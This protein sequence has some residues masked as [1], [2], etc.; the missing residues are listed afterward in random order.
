MNNNLYKILQTTF[1]FLHFA[2]EWLGGFVKWAT[3]YFGTTTQ[4]WYFLSHLLL[5]P[6]LAMPYFIKKQSAYIMLSIQMAIFVNVL[7]HLIATMLFATYAPGVISGTFLIIPYSI[8]IFAKCYQQT[9]LK[10]EQINS[11]LIFGLLISMIIIAT[12][13]LDIK[14]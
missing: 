14:I 2:E 4:N 8:L 5:I 12:L 10:K 6:L 1:I 11:A 3:V 13:Y 7:F 9:D